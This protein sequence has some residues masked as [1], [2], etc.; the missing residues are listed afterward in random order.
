MESPIRIEEEPETPCAR[1]EPVF[2]EID[3]G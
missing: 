3:A 1:V 2:R